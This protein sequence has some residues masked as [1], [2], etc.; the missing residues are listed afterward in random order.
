MANTE[1]PCRKIGGDV[2]RFFYIKKITVDTRLII[3]YLEVKIN[4]YIK[5]S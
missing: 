2:F 1:H 3:I 5:V 4:N